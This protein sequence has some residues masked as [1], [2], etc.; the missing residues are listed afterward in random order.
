MTHATTSPSPKEARTAAASWWR[1]AARLVAL[2]L[3]LVLAVP[4]A[5]AHAHEPGPHHSV[6]HLSLEMGQPATDD[7]SPDRGPAH[8]CASCACHQVVIADAGGMLVPV[9]VTDEVPF[10]VGEAAVTARATAPPR[11]PPRA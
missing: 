1:L 8:H 9:R 11:K 5:D 10:I 4:M 7:V 3:I 2:L 6:S